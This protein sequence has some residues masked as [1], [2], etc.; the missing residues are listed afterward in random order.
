MHNRR[1]TMFAALLMVSIFA[2][3]GCGPRATGGSAAAI[4]GSDNAVVDLP[5]IVIDIDDEGN[6][7]VGG[8]PI[9]TVA[10]MAGVDAAQLDQLI[11]PADIVSQLK[12]GNIQHIQIDN[13]IDGIIVLVNGEPIPFFVWDETSLVTT[14]ETLETF[15]VSV[16]LLDR[17]LPLIRTI[18]LAAVIRLPIADGNEPIPTVVAGDSTAAAAAQAAQAEFLAA[19]GQ[20]PKIQIVVDYAPDG[21]WQVGGL[22]QEEWSQIAPLPWESLNLDPGLIAGAKEAG[23][24]TVVLATNPDGI[25]ISLN[26]KTLPYISWN[27][28]EVAHTLKLA[29]QLGLLDSMMG[30]DSDMGQLLGT[31]ESLL[32]MVQASDVNMVVN[33]R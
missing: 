32:P 20:A 21:T 16:A 19:A 24:N 1:L 27:N 12:D 22:S 8:L 13:S 3:V 9:T 14:A 7:S 28:G 26:D 15:G 11:I 2:L 33:F 17:V 25:F 6:P 23:V 5:A 10:A 18:G 30:A 29:G 31:I 4:A